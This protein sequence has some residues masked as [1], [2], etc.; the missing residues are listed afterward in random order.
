[1]H[2]VREGDGLHGLSGMPVPEIANGGS[3]TAV[4]GRKNSL[5]WWWLRK[6]RSS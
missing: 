5:C 6:V 4:S 3:H 1:V 2:I